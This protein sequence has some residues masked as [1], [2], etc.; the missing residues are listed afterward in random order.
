MLLAFEACANEVVHPSITVKKDHPALWMGSYYRPG[1]SSQIGRIYFKPKGT[2]FTFYPARVNANLSNLSDGTLKEKRSISLSNKDSEVA[3]LVED[4]HLC[5][6]RCL[7]VYLVRT[8]PFREGKWLLFISYQKNKSSY[9]SKN[10][11]L[12]GLELLST[13]CTPILTKT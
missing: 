1:K 9:I 6:V 4:R 5:S 7:K 10:T 2:S 12:V 11:S 13:V 3:H 8:K